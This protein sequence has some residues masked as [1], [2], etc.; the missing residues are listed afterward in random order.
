MLVGATINGNVI[1]CFTRDS[2]HLIPFALE[3]LALCGFVRDT[4]CRQG[5]W[6]VQHGIPTYWVRTVVRS[7]VSI[8]VWKYQSEPTVFII[9]WTNNDLLFLVVFSIGNGQPTKSMLMAWQYPDQP[10]GFC[11]DTKQ[12]QGNP[13]GVWQVMWVYQSS[14]RHCKRRGEM[15]GWSAKLFCTGVGDD[16]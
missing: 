4:S 5:C 3:C 10:L 14:S 2:M 9:H 7:K 12:P 8:I 11:H 15:L 6:I 13:H 16:G 1:C